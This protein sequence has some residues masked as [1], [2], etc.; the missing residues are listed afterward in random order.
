[1]TLQQ[2]ARVFES[3]GF[4]NAAQ[5]IVLL[6]LAYHADRRGIVR[7]SQAEIAAHAGMS[8]RTVARWVAHFTEMGLLERLGHGRY[9]LDMEPFDW[10][11]G[12]TPL[13]RVPDPPVPVRME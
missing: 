4:H 7:F 8:L 9:K 1:M 11:E 5:Y 3:D 12:V 2:V 10:P 6:E 13:L